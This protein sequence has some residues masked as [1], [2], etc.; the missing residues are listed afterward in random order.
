MTLVQMRN[1]GGLAP[2][3]AL[4][5]LESQFNNFFAPVHRAVGENGDAYWTPSA[6]L[7]ETDNAFVVELDIPGVKKED[8]RI[9]LVDNVATIKGERKREAKKDGY[10]HAERSYGKFERTIEIP[11]GFDGA[12]VEA[13]FENG[14]LRV[15]LPKKEEA[16]SRLVEVT[17]N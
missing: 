2:W 12:G 9:E 4:N 14:V 13:K 7:H 5:E 3:N 15:T 1:R 6:D 16:T 17:A 11:G 10:R 8:I